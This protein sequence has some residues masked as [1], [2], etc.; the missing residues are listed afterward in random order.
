MCQT[1]DKIQEKLCCVRRPHHDRASNV[2]K[3]LRK[4]A[5]EEELSGCRHLRCGHW[6]EWTERGRHIPCFAITRTDPD[7]NNPAVFH[8][9]AECGRHS[10][11]LG[12]DFSLRILI[13]QVLQA[14]AGNTFEFF[15]FS[16]GDVPSFPPMSPGEEED[17]D[18]AED[19]KQAAACV[20]VIAS[21]EATMD[22]EEISDPWQKPENFPKLSK[23]DQILTKRAL[24]SS[25]IVCS[26]TDAV[27]KNPHICW[28]VEAL[29]LPVE[30]IQTVFSQ[31]N[32]RDNVDKG[33]QNRKVFRLMHLSLSIL[34]F[35]GVLVAP[36]LDRDPIA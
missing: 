31:N 29:G 30:A 6:H 2:Q 21:N 5:A 34:P 32:G 9:V 7:G 11:D 26:P 27:T 33:R 22:A 28:F 15:G 13:P 4:F 25:E 24:Q 12:R 8:L 36:P 35:S 16:K 14:E 3:A 17:D 1:K 20:G 19:A 18:K 10:G 23:G